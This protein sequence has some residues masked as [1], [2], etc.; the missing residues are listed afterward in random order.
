MIQKISSWFEQG[1]FGVCEWW[2]KK[3]GIKSSTI[4]MYFIYLSFFT[5][6]SPIII[7]FIMAFILE[8]KKY[9]IPHHKRKSSVWEI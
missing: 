4:R 6:G 1:A 2:G 3:L 9:F 7:Y 8:H 5:A